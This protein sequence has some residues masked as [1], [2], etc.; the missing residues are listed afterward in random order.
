M[1]FR[2]GEIT[3]FYPQMVNS[4]PEEQKP[5]RPDE[6]KSL[7]TLEVMLRPKIDINTKGINDQYHLDVDRRDE[8]GSRRPLVSSGSNRGPGWP[9]S[10]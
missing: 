2:P 8:P 6:C 9:R 1:R 4:A 7:E 5:S 10:R 3:T